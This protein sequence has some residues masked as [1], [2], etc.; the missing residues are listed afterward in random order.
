M[1]II[2]IQETNM[3]RGATAKLFKRD[4]NKFTDKHDYYHIFWGH[5]DEGETQGSGV[6]LLMSPFWRDHIQRQVAF[7]GRTQAVDFHFKTGFKIR[8][9][10]IYLPSRN[11][12]CSEAVVH[13][14]KNEYGNAREQGYAIVMLGDYNGVMNPKMDRSR[15][16]QSSRP[17]TPFLQW[18][19]LQALHDSYRLLHPTSR[20]YTLGNKS[21][22]DMIFVSTSLAERFVTAGIKQLGD[23]VSSDHQMATLTLT[24]HGTQHLTRQT[25]KKY[26]KPKGFRFQLKET[27]HEQWTL[28]ETELDEALRKSTVADALGLQMPVE[29]DAEQAVADY[30]TVDLNKIWN[31][32]SKT[33]LNIAKK[34]L[35]GKIVGRSGVRPGAE[36]DIRNIIQ[37]LARLKKE[38]K[39]IVKGNTAGAETSAAREALYD[40]W[41]RVARFIEQYNNRETEKLGSLR[42]TPSLASTR[43]DWLAWRQE[44]KELWNDSIIR[45][46]AERVV[47]TRRSIKE[48]VEKRCEQLKTATGK[49]L[50]KILNRSRGKVVIDRVQAVV[51][52]ISVNILEP[53]AIK[54]HVMEWFH[55]WHGPRASTTPAAGSRWEK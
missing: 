14:I 31:W 41:T 5:G 2:G 8:I 44:V 28:Y 36:I 37:G 47:D 19:E 39:E 26:K 22:I 13:W 42:E 40:D 51:D 45:L 46:H 6:A 11:D 17:E 9:I 1:D 12:K 24:L 52:G 43:A 32:Y 30:E 15:V 50:D 53:G 34:T 35:P 20:D 10:N 49:M 33:V 25:A 54:Q 55:K 4:T 18:V 16:S 23:T 29:G 48:A 38:S 7:K 3:T 27:S 21:R